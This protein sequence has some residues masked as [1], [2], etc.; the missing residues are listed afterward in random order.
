M[1][2]SVEDYIKNHI[3]D[4]QTV[5]VLKETE[6]PKYGKT[7][8]SF[9]AEG[10]LNIKGQFVTVQIALDDNFPLSKPLF[11][12][13]PFDALGFI[14][15]VDNCGFIC[16]VHDEGLIIDKKSITVIIDEAFERVLKTLYDGISGANYRDIQDEF[17]SYWSNLENI[18]IIESNVELTNNVK[19]IKAI[20]FENYP[21]YFVGD[22]K[23]DIMN[24]CSK[25]IGN[26]HMGKATFLD[27]DALY[28]PLREGTNI[29][30]PYYG[31]FWEVSEFRR[32][33]L[34][35]VTGSNK[36]KIEKIAKRKIRNNENLICLIS[37]PLSNGNKALIGVKYS[38]F[39]PKEKSIKKQGFPHPLNK[40]DYN[41]LFV[42]LSVERHDK[43]YILPRGGGSNSLNDKKVALIGCGSIGGYVAVEL[44]KAGIQNIT[45]IDHDILMQENVY[46]HVLGINSI[47]SEDYKKNKDSKETYNP[48][49]LELK[50]E[51]EKKLPYTNIEVYA[52]YINKIENIIKNGDIDFKKFDLVIVA[53]GNPTIEL[54]LNEYFH[55]KPGMP[56]IIFSWLEAYGVGGHAV[57][58]NNNNKNGC[59]KCLYTNPFNRNAPLYNRA[60]FSEEGQ[61]F[62]KQITGC[63]S[64]Y[65]PY[66]SLDSIQTTII[67]TRLAI[68]VL[69]GKEEDN[70]VLSWKGSADMF[71][72]SG[73][74]LSEHYS[75]SSEELFSSRYLYKDASCEICGHSK[76]VQNV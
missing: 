16:Y 76:D 70:P 5:R 73:F 63:S 12:L 41:C 6:Y 25:Y 23:S 71:L 3:L 42:P 58:T 22:N 34:K 8:F 19:I 36:R 26:T 32:L 64:V 46:R 74:K 24:Y 4:Y 65:M 69:S 30:P 45:L 9:V 68:D 59:L 21:F 55:E 18:S 44:A 7:K 28:I 61:F 53:I 49:I 50:S 62:A 11:F 1:L 67:A 60:S 27:T 17:E 33:I 37:I 20:Q 75:L 47:K 54:C 10:E 2:R 43:G 31:T 66:S 56:P 40:T 29:T 57:L 51:I 72:D 35:N 14:P 38:N 15:H 52:K 13:K 39:S 48:K